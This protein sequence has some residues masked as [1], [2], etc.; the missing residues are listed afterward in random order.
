MEYDFWTIEQGSGPVASVAIHDGHGMRSELAGLLAIN[1]KDRL[2]E[3][4]PFTA[5]LTEIAHNRI[6]VKSSR[7]EVDLNRPRDKAVYRT[8]DDAWGLNVWKQDL[9]EDVIERSLV[10][11]DAF[12]NEAFRLLKHLEDSY[13]RFIVL[14]LHSYCHRRNGPNTEPEPSEENPDINIGTATVDK[15]LW[16]NLVNHF[17]ADLRNYPFPGRLFLLIKF[18][19]HI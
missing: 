5:R 12:Y 15:L 1:E 4:D 19:T 8:P 11:Y 6:I 7:F 17:M 3:E 14:D 13:G 9:S 2:R 10:R 18:V 16:S